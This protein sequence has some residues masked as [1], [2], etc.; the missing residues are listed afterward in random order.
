MGGR[1]V[2]GVTA[3][4]DLLPTL[5]DLC[6]LQFEDRLRFDGVSLARVLTGEV[7]A[8]AER[9]VVVHNQGRF[10]DPVGDGLLIK[11]KEYSVMRGS[12]RLVGQELFDLRNDPSQRSDIAR[13]HPGV[14]SR[15]RDD[16][17]AWWRSVFERSD[18]YCPFVINPAKQ[19]A[20]MIT[21]QSLL[22]SN[23]AY[24]Q[25]HVRSGMPIS[26]WTVIDVEA[27]GTYRISL[28]RW[29][30]EA[31]AAIRATVPPCPV[32]PSTH[33]MKKVLC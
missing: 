16:Y 26:G 28:R 22:G 8:I 14:A 17:E 1:D 13:Q 23:V 7:R 21:S 33:Q 25:R 5:I 4:I 10:A 3:H 18:E 29:P 30:K 31:S 32:D 9:S 15:L 6:G 12:W 24:S 11:D 27:P 2:H 19:E 20:M